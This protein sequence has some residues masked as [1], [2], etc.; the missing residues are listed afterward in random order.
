MSEG[1]SEGVN[2]YITYTTEGTW[3]SKPR[4]LPT[5]LPIANPRPVP[6]RHSD[7]LRARSHR[8]ASHPLYYNTTLHYTTTA[9]CRGRVEVG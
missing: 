9:A 7:S 1:V 5:Y 2:T 4:S 3:R 6:S 8:I